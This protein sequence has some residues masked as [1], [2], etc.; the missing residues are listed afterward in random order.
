M[1]A[2][3][4]FSRYL[5]LA[6]GF[7][8][9]G[10]LPSLLASVARKSDRQAMRLSGLKDDLKLFQALCIAWFRGDYRAISTQALLAA[11]GALLYFV[12]PLDGLPD[13]I[14]GFGYIDDLAVL[15]WVARTWSDELQAFRLWRE[16]Q[17][18]EQQLLLEH[19]PDPDE[20]PALPVE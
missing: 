12:T 7:I 10:R 8:R 6:K 11:V 2:P 13:W 19:I 15:A 4:N 9:R 3:W 16:Q 18:P 20:S 14:L 5:A 17:T 1:K